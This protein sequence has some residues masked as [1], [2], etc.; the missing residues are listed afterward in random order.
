M[1][2]F[3]IIPYTFVFLPFQDPQGIRVHQWKNLDTS[4]G[5]F[6]FFLS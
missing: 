6:Q 2:P 4:T 5:M 3:D 1:V